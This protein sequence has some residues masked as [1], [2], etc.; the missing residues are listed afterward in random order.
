MRVVSMSV[1]VGAVACGAVSPVVPVTAPRPD[2][3]VD[4]GTLPAGAQLAV[5]S[6]REISTRYAKEGDSFIGTVTTPIADDHGDWPVGCVKVEGSVKK[7]VR[8]LAERTPALYLS[9]ERVSVGGQQTPLHGR[10]S[11]VQLNER[12]SGD[13]EQ[14]ARAARIWGG[15]VG[16]LT[17][18][19]YGS[20][21]INAYQGRN[22]AASIGYLNTRARAEHELYGP[23]GGVVT[24]E[25]DRALAV[26]KP[27]CPAATYAVPPIT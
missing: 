5:R 8:G 20:G 11:S 24:L 7:V 13:P 23:A 9:V 4:R 14:A 1:L 15:F 19:W 2:L 27:A 18:R 26:P 22:L 17:G 16:A 10:V 3:I 25:L 12:Q 21:L 6:D